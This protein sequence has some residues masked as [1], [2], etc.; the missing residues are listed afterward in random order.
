MQPGCDPGQ[1]LRW[2]VSGT[3]GPSRQPAPV[4][5]DVR[6]DGGTSDAELWARIFGFYSGSGERQYCSVCQPCP[7][8]R[9]HPV[10]SE[11]VS[12]P[13][14]PSPSLFCSPASLCRLACMHAST[15]TQTHLLPSLCGG[16]L[17]H[18][19]SPRTASSEPLG[20]AVLYPW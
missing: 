17:F 6:H 13:E 1:G 16:C 7:F 8:W 20:L 19:E 11:R 4:P 18:T 3:V 12:C 2:R 15:Q 9:S 5:P 10:S 14:L